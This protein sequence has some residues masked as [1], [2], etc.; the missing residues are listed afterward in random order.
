MV[1]YECMYADCP[2]NETKVDAVIEDFKSKGFTTVIQAIDYF[3]NIYN[4][5]V[6]NVDVFSFE[7][8][9]HLGYEFHAVVYQ[10]DAII[11]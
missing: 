10:F 4:N 2:V 5:C 7:E 8:M 1:V 3:N 6:S 11:A 9:I